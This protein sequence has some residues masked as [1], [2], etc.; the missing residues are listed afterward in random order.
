VR[1]LRNGLPVVALACVFFPAQAQAIC[2]PIDRITLR[3]APTLSAADIDALIAPFTGRCLGLAEFDAVLE[4]V[5]LAYVD[6][7]LILSRAYLPQQDLSDGELEI[8]VVEGELTGITINGA[9]DPRW[10]GMVFPGMAGRPVNIRDVEQGLDQIEAMPRWSAEMVFEPGSGPGE[11]VMAVTA[12]SAKPT[13]YRIAAHNRGSEDSGEWV[14]TLGVN[15]THLFGINDSWDLSVSKSLDPHPLA[16]GYGGDSSRT[17]ALTFDIPYGRWSL[18]YE[19]DYSDYGQTVAGA[20]SDIPTSGTTLGQTLSADYLIFRDTSAKHTVGAALSRV[21]T[22]NEIAGVQI[23]A[24]SRIITGLE[25]SYGV[26]DTLWGGAFDGRVYVGQGLRLLGAEDP[27]EQPEGTPDAQYTLAG[28]QVDY[29]RSFPELRDLRWSLTLQGQMSADRL[30]GGQAF[31]I[32]GTSTVRGTRGALA[33]GSSGVVLR[34]EGEIPLPVPQTSWLQSAALYGALDYGQI[35]S[36]PDVDVAGAS[37]LGAALGAKLRVFDLSLD[38]S[39]QEV[40]ALNGGGDRPSG[41]VLIEAEY[42]F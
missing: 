26:T 25:L 36:Q 6:R 31:S 5:T 16:L 14:T 1:R 42:V 34:N 24:S 41:V 15:T 29:S 37:A 10:S 40:L 32:G 8:A 28:V 17:A 38:V 9:A 18:G 23:E 35:F 12:Q 2:L 19:L 13:A 27:T 21:V 7:G 20:F 4:A 30:Y 11:S 39:Y 3:A 22:E 33:S